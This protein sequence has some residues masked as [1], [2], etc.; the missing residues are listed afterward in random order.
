[1]PF[2]KVSEPTSAFGA[3]DFWYGKG[4]I[5]YPIAHTALPIDK[6]SLG[7]LT[8]LSEVFASNVTQTF[9]A[10]SGT[11]PQVAPESKIIIDTPS[12]ALIIFTGHFWYDVSNPGMATAKIYRHT[13]INGHEII[14]SRGLFHEIAPGK[15]FE[16]VVDDEIFFAQIFEFALI[17]PGRYEIQY[18]IWVE[19]AA[20]LTSNLQFKWSDRS[21]M[22]YAQ[23]STEVGI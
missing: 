11:T 13:T 20:S 23:F 3:G 2:P 17:E 14:P 1:M 22:G 21:F 10:A 8:G 5:G 12:K 7:I 19:N 6:P 15:G 18:E 16:V 9:T 4:L